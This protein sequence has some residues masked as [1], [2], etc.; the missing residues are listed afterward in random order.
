M[1]TCLLIVPFVLLAINFF[2]IYQ[3]GLLASWERKSSLGE[4]NWSF[5]PS[6]AFSSQRALLSFEDP[7]EEKDYLRS[8]ILVDDARPLTIKNYLENYHSHLVPNADLI[9]EA[10]IRVGLS[11]Y[12]VV[13]ISQQESNLCKKVPPNCF[14]CWGIGIHS[15]G[16]L[17][18]ESYEQGIKKA[19]KYFKE[20]YLDK[21]LETPEQ[22]MGKYCP[23]SDGS[24]AAGI[25]QFLGELEQGFSSSQ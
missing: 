1:G 9:F 5:S 13:A 8:T 21:G 14:N 2:I 4:K 16:T 18:Y 22:M 12:L 6:F 23:L 24:W 15:R 25:N 19:I 10:S 20:E 3:A 17:C 11:P 7:K